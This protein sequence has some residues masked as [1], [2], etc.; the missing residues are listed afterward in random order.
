MAASEPGS[1]G[2]FVRTHDPDRFLT[3]M[4]APPDRREALLALYAFNFEVARVREVV[5]DAM[6]GQIRLQWW[7]DALTEIATGRPPRQHEVVQPLAA[8]IARHDLPLAV[9]ERL[10]DARELDLDD[11]PP[12]DLASLFA[13]LDGASG[14]LVD[15]ALRI[16][17]VEAP[18]VAHAAGIGFGLAGLLRALPF[19]AGADRIYLPAEAMARHGVARKDLTAGQGG[20]GLVALVREVAGHAANHLDEA[21]HLSRDLPRAAVPALLP[22][23]VARGWLKDLGRNGHDPFAAPAPRPLARLAAVTVAGLRGRI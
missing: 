13:Y 23:T 5:S 11:Q 12:P 22:V 14:A 20:A 10:I 6:I 17:G 15:L 3:A 2:A 8:A 1:P 21:R 9:F 16:L 18:A 7:R 19:H 4:F